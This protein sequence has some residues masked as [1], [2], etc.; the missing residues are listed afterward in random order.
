MES[1]E[2]GHGTRA[3]MGQGQGHRASTWWQVQGAGARDKG[4]RQ[5]H[6]KRVRGKD[7]RNGHR[8]RPWEKATG[9]GHGE[10]QI[11][12]HDRPVIQTDRSSYVLD[13]CV[14]SIIMKIF[15]FSSGRNPTHFRGNKCDF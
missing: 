4:R 11:D 10:S 9:Q 12:R 7:T 8:K 14:V 1:T 2:Q 3:C 6:W 5:W 15:I 13:R